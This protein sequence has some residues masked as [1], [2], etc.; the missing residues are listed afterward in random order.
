MPRVKIRDIELYYEVHGHGRPLILIRGFGSNADHWYAQVP[1]LSERFQVVVFDNRGIARSD[2]PEG[3]YSIPMMSEDT[4]GLME[5]LGLGPAH[6][7][8]MSMGG[9]I[10]Q[11]TALRYPDKVRGLV[12]ACTHC[13][14]ERAVRASEEVTKIFAEY[15]MTGSEEAAAKTVACLFAEKT[16]KEAPEVAAR[17]QAEAARFRP[18]LHVLMSQFQAVQGH[19][20]WED[21]IRIQAPT[22]V[23]TGGQDVLVPPENSKILA[24][25]IPNA[26]LKV[27]DGG[28]HQFNIERPDE[29]NGAVIEF[30]EGLAG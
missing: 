21:L 19:D 14:G 25:R 28:A 24:E 2:Q 29:F 3:P 22:L 26:R 10:A 30:L 15:V 6:V 17:Y 16:L 20:I 23:L 4:E 1:A 13:G 8:G 9:M 12:L 11:V 18:P 7:L 27:I 5:A